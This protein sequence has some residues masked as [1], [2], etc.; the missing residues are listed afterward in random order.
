MF[1]QI[2]SCALIYNGRS[3]SHVKI[4]FSY[5]TK[6]ITVSSNST[7]ITQSSVCKKEKEV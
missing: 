1:I 3:A 7:P 4:N 2:A 5:L 6:T